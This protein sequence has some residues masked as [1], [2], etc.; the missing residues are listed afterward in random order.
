METM[1]SA[2]LR[3]KKLF[4]DRPAIV[5]AEKNF[6]WGEHLDRVEKLAGALA[7]LGINKGDR[8]GIIGP[9]TFR[10]TELIHAS[11]WAGAIP[12]PINH[13]LAPPEI[14]HILELSLIH[15]SEPTRPY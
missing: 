6:T 1:T 14:I 10:Y 5:D 3:T 7:G 11:Y 4:G 12:V 15:I 13:R 2:L 9:N 8:F